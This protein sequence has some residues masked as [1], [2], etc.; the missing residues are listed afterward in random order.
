MTEQETV[1]K[2]MTKGQ[3]FRSFLSLIWQL[4]PAIFIWL[5]LGAVLGSVQALFTAAIP[6]WLIDAYQQGFDPQRFLQLIALLVAGKFALLQLNKVIANRQDRQNELLTQQFVLTLAEKVS[7]IDYANLEDPE[8]LDLKERGQFALTNYGALQQFFLSG[9]RGATGILTLLG[10]TALLIRF[11]L[12]LFLVILLL[13]ILS[14]VLSISALAQMQKMMQQLIPINRVYNYFFNKTFQPDLQKEFRIFGMHLL[15]DDRIRELNKGTIHWL[16]QMRKLQ[17]KTSSGQA[18]LQYLTA[19]AA[20]T[21]AALRALGRVTGTRI[22]IG[23][24]TFYV[25]ISL[26][27]S[28]AVF[29]TGQAVFQVAQA[30][31][32]LEPFATFMAIED[33]AEKSGKQEVPDFKNLAFR[34]VSF[35]YPGSERLVLDKVSFE[36][37]QG[38]HISI[39]GLN[40]AGKTTIIKL[41]CRLFEPDSGE[42]LYNGVPIQEYDYAQYIAGLSAVFQ[43][44]K[45]FPFT[46]R[47]NLDPE[48]RCETD[49]AVFRV[50]DEAG[51]GEKVRSFPQQLDS[52]L[53]KSLRDDAVECSGGEKQKLAIARAMLKRS[54]LL[55]LD[56]PTA[57]LDP[58]AE[59]EVYRHFSALTEGRTAIFISHR[60]SSSVFCDKILVIDQGRVSAFDTHQNLMAGDNLYR[61]LFEAQ[62]K[63]YLEA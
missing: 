16:L 56:E 58:L 26:Q 18:G 49:A 23:D 15:M 30:L 53:D 41:L 45:F 42:I 22:G 59:S 8:L 38:E 28:T 63:N 14:N 33:S 25:G 2:P 10:V 24:F 9:M 31:D 32:M 7:R 48:G 61:L 55:I 36:I 62:A 47:E 21:Y 37:H 11:S 39:V 60:M 50:L 40:N 29:N 46:L 57:A 35:R 4:Q 44:F 1:R 52:Y 20:M 5:L 34:G 51:V 43:D 19:F 6:K 12:P 17:A 13:T 27:F 54:D 3:I